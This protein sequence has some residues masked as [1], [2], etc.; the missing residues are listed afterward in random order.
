MDR[1]LA[2]KRPVGPILNLYAIGDARKDVI[3][4]SGTPM[5]DREKNP[6]VI[7]FILEGN[8][9]AFLPSDVESKSTNLDDA[10]EGNLGNRIKDKIDLPGGFGSNI[11][12]KGSGSSAA[13]PVDNQAIIITIPG[14][15]LP[16]Q[17]AEINR[18]INTIN[19]FYDSETTVKTYVVDQE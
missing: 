6:L 14:E 17:E 9:Q 3:G 10:P 19:T 4:V 16:V 5:P 18:V 8:H 2:D 11:K 7:T 13:V 15:N 1:P 12:A